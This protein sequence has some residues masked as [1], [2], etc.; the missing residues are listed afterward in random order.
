[1]GI[2]GLTAYINKKGIS[3]KDEVTLQGKPLIIDGSALMWKLMYNAPGREYGGDYD[4]QYDYLN[5]F[6]KTVKR[7]KIKMT[8]LIDGGKNVELKLKTFESRQ[9][10]RI[11]RIIRFNYEGY[12]YRGSLPFPLFSSFDEVLRENEIPF[13]LC[14]G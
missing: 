3:F 10:K 11:N 2:R 4:A 8:V 5:A 14:D 12:E 9:Q 1:M 13:V 7:M 6:F